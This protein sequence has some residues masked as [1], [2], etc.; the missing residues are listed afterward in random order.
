MFW[1]EKLMANVERDRRNQI[2]LLEMGWDV[3]VIWECQ[4]KQISGI[5]RR[6]T[7]FLEC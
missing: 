5:Q 4:L 3:W 7:E 6:A 2:D 1:N